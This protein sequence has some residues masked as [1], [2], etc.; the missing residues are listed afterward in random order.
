MGLELEMG[1]GSG[2]G[3]A[4]DGWREAMLWLAIALALSLQ[5][6]TEAKAKSLQDALSAAYFYSPRLDAERARLRATDEDVVRAESGYRPIVEGSA[7]LSWQNTSSKPKTDAN[8]ETSPWGYSI[9]IRQSVFNGFQTTNGVA[10]AEASVKA[11]REDLRQAE[12]SILLDAVEAYMSVVSAQAVVRIRESSVKVL[13]EELEAARLRRQ[14]REVTRTDVAQAQ[15]RLARAVSTADLAKSDLKT[16]RALFER[17]VGHA[18]GKLGLPSMTVSMLP[19]RIEDAWQ[20]AERNNP[21]VSSALHREEAARFAVDKVRGE[22]L[23]QV[24][25]EANYGYRENQDS[26]YQQ[27][28]S[29]TITGRVSVPFY[30]GGE[31]RARVRQAKH[32]HVSRLQEIEQ[33]RAD[34]QANVTS[35]WSTLMGQRAKLKSDEVQVD[36]NKIALEGVREEQKVGQ[37]TLLDVLNAEQEY[38]DLQIELVSARREVVVASYKVLAATGQ[39]TVEDLGLSATV[40]DPVAHLEDTRKDWFGINITHADGSR[41]SM[42]VH[43]RGDGA[44]AK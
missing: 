2:W 6:L 38:Y 31:T 9:S 4:R 42:N 36:A 16:A 11:G 12:T 28:D 40:Y 3:I 15:A 17:V 37:R 43:D 22:L 32:I 8:G 7:D 10:E 35:S 30:D 24:S 33:A 13:A 27:Q 29:A 26:Y 21:I 19:S 20:T 23:P 5:S 39:L 41:E 14:A 18:P 1:F 34:A 44:D 25:L